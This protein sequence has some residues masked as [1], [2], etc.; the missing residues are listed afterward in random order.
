MPSLSGCGFHASFDK[1]AIT[2]MK[3]GES[4]HSVGMLDQDAASAAVAAIA[5]AIG[6]DM[7]AFETLVAST[8]VALTQV[9]N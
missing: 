8:R 6:V 3:Q 5:P 9:F 2:L 7:D 1:Y 4:G